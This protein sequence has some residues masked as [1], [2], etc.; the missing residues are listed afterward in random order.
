MLLAGIALLHAGLLVDAHAQG[1]I[2]LDPAK[3]ISQYIH[4]AWETEDGLPQNSVS[5]L[6]QSQN[7]Y[8]WIGTEEGLVRFDGKKHVVFD[9]KTVEAFGVNDVVTILEASDGALFIGTRGAGVVVYDGI[10]F[11]TITEEDGLKSAFITSLSQDK[12]G[13][14]WIGTYGGGLAKYQNNQITSYGP[15]AGFDGEFISEVLQDQEGNVWVGT[16]KGLYRLVND[17]FVLYPNGPLN[18]AFITSMFE[19]SDANL[20]IATREHGFYAVKSDTALQQSNPV[21]DEG[22]VTSI[23]Q[24]TAGSLW[25][26]MT[27]GKL[28]RLKGPSLLE[29]E[30][31][32]SLTDGDFLALIEDKEGSLWLGTRGDGLHRL[33]NDKF[34]PYGIPEGIANDRAYSIFEKENKDLWIGTAAGLSLL[35]QNEIASFPLA[36]TLAGKEILSVM[37]DGGP[38]LWVGTYGEGLFYI[39]DRIIRQFT[40]SNGLAS[41]NIFA[42]KTDAKG[43][44]WIGTDE[45]VSIYDG[46]QFRSLTTDQALPSPFITAIEESHDGALWIGTYD[47]GFVRYKEGEITQY[48]TEQGLSTAGVLSLYEDPE[49]I[50]WIGTYGGGLNRLELNNLTSYTTRNGLYNDNVYVIL[51]DNANNLWMSCNKGIFSVDKAVLKQI[52]RGDSVLIES[53]V[54]DKHDGLRSAEGTGGQQPAGWKS[55][56]GR[57]WFPTIEGV[58]SV[59]PLA[60]TKN[61]VKPP[62]VIEKLVVDNETISLHE[63][64]R[65]KAGANKLQI[66]F[67]ALSFIVPE[68]VQFQYILEGADQEWSSPDIRREAFYN[69]LPPGNYTFRVKASNN[70]G[71]WNEEGATLS[72]Y[73]EPHFYQTLWFKCTVFLL[74]VLFGFL[75]YRMRIQQLKARQEELERVVE[76]RTRDLRLEKEKTEQSKLVI[77]AQAEKL[78]ELDRFKTRFFANISHEFRTPLTMII[79]PLENAIGGIYGPMQ[80]SLKRQV[81]IMLRNAQRLLRLINQ[82][83]D[84]SKLEAGKMELRAQRRNVVQFLEDILLSC[85]P[86]ADKKEINLSFSTPAKEIGLFYEPDKLEKIFFNLLSNALKFTPKGGSISFEL[87]EL[88]ASPKFTEGAIEIRVSDTGRGIPAADLPHIFDR[89]HQVDGSNTREHEGSG[90]GLALVHELVMLH[91][92]LIDVESETGKGTTF[93]VR[94]PLGNAHLEK[95]QVSNTILSEGSTNS[96]EVHV[97]TELAQ[98]SG[99]F[100]HEEDSPSVHEPLLGPH[101]WIGNKV[102]LIIDDNDDVREYVSSILSAHYTVHTAFD[103]VDGL[104]K[105]ATVDPDLVISDVMMPRMDGNELCKRIKQNLDYDHIPV[106]LMTAKATNELKIEGLEMGADDYIAKP[107]NARELLVRARNL[108]IMRHQEKEL[109]TLNDDLESKVAEQLDQMLTERLKY[110]EELVL[111]KEKAETSSRLKSN[112]LDNVNHEFR[113]PIAGIMGSAEI[114]EMDADDSVQE[115]VGFIKQSAYRLQSTLDAVVELSSLESDSITLLPKALNFTKILQDLVDRFKPMATNKGVQFYPRIGHEDVHIY[116]DEHAIT[117]VLD[118]LTDNA[119]KFTHDG[120]IKVDLTVENDLVNLTIKDTGIG[121]STEFMPRLF[122]AFVQESDGISRS[123]EGIGIGLTISKRLVEL[124]NGKLTAKSVKNEGTLIT[125]VFPLYQF[126]ETEEGIADKGTAD[127]GT[128]V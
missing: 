122:D 21:F 5:S 120:Q 121:I 20:W 45:G 15:E 18:E 16:E 49:G 54:Y 59:D 24:D 42:L 92:G 72:F 67:T 113:T 95:E 97:I 47:A 43:Q 114:L 81:G 38:G 96:S 34:T 127:K 1:Q 48:S 65:L 84:L 116:A 66:E 119:I 28:V 71:I 13:N 86:L 85:T 98:Q 68:R 9:K 76:E 17:E 6:V 117:R 14:V 64:V 103:G 12:S 80:D 99:D 55:H 88:E 128:A 50:L 19:D 40:T 60:L 107:F 106:I 104:E 87:A 51:E 46:Q 44:L 33:R 82:L 39:Q 73:L 94:F 100:D 35:R 112:I 123:Y 23:L 56:D 102:V 115:F 57:L 105:V 77:E 36:D 25:I 4:E 30:S 118:H 126:S 37:D 7:G 8:L 41:N 111:A 110:E 61:E 29:V 79:G 101:P 62:I 58:A 108:M 22:Y 93:I 90:I 124:M 69:N 27:R 52:A 11:S 91:K 2:T 26:G 78:K 109:K 74:A 83:L 63:D 53:H 31:N 125:L 75:L 70:D 3:Q 10:Q 89:F 32:Q